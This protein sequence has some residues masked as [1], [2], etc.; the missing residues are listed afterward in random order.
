MF[1]SFNYMKNYKSTKSN[2]HRPRQAIVGYPIKVSKTFKQFFVN[3]GE[4]GRK[5]KGKKR[6]K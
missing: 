5:K 4:G 1:I 6:R 3:C 2:M